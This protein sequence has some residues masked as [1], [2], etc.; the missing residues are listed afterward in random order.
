MASTYSKNRWS[1]QW[2]RLARSD[3]RLVQEYERKQR[4]SNVRLRRENVN[5]TGVAPAPSVLSIGS[6]M[7]AFTRPEPVLWITL[8]AIPV[9]VLL[10]SC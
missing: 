9:D 4:T 7:G 8:A 10:V 5:S 6:F 2:S 3:R 1:R